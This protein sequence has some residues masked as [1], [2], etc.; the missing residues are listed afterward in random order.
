MLAEEEADIY[1]I[2]EQTTFETN[3]GWKIQ[4]EN[5][6]TCM[7]IFHIYACFLLTFTWINGVI[8]ARI[9]VWP[10]DEEHCVSEEEMPAPAA[11]AV[12][13]GSTWEV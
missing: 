3:G 12:T 7:Q 5:V 8:N 6:H 13:R 1:D 10:E 4:K 11:A 9:Q 2:C